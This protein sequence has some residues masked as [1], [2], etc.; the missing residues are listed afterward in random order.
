MASVAKQQPSSTNPVAAPTGKIKDFDNLRNILRGARNEN[1][2]VDLYQ[3]LVEIM[4]HIVIHC[5]DKGLDQF[6][7]ISYL[8]K[9]KDEIDMQEFLKIS[10][11]YDYNIQSRYF[12][13][14]TEEYGQH[15]KKFFE[16][17]Q[18]QENPDDGEEVAPVDL[19]PTGQVP[20]LLNDVK[21]FQYG[22]VGFGDNETLL[23]QKSLKQHSIATGA[24]S[25]RLWGKIHGTEK[26]YYI[27]EGLG[28]KL[29]EGGEIM[30]PPADFEVRGSGVNKYQYWACNSPLGKWILLPDL[31]PKDIKAARSIKVNFSGNL[32][33][34]IYTNPYFFGLEKHYLRAQIAR[35][36]HSTTIVPSG[37][38]K[39][40]DDN[41]REIEENTPEEGPIKMPSTHAVANPNAW[42]HYTPNILKCNR[43]GHMEVEPAEDEDP[44]VLKA[45]II[46]ADPFEKRL[47]PISQDQ[48]VRGGLPSWTVKH[49]GDQTIFKNINPAVQDGQNYGVVVCKSLQWPGSYTFYSQSRYLQVYVGDGLKY[50]Q[51]TYYPVFPP[52]IMDD[53]VERYHVA[54]PFGTYE[55][56]QPV[57]PN[58]E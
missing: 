22:G 8:L 15:A 1:G 44:E 4:N 48:K 47:K 2:S 7:E 36:S 42:V 32:D 12:S 11:K 52:K 20:D 31:L 38:N 51:Q 16:N 35:I 5:P 40:T 46:A 18:Q 19:A 17:K 37:L 13:Q 25:I 23:L 34:P 55:E 14:V 58:Y 39:V 29:E 30:E 10:E 50:E 49:H 24:D 45:K 27:A 43:L 3:H 28:S 56:P 33:R 6:E 53:P 57:D 21:I 9:H 41:D 54:E 26:D